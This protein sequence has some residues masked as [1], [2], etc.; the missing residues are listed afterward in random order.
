M[1][2]LRHHAFGPPAE[3]LRL[4]DVPMPEPGPGEVRVRLTHRGINLAD[5]LTIR[6]RYGRRPT[7]PAVGGNEGVGVV[8]AR[9]EGV[10]GLAVGQRVVPLGAGP[11]WQEYL[12]APPE[13]LLPV[14]A[15]VS[16]E[17]AAQLYVN[18]LTAWL[19]LERVADAAESLPRTRSGGDA[20]VLTAGASAVARCAI[21]LAA[22]RGLRPIAIVRRGEHADALRAL[23]AEVLVADANGEDARAQLRAL[24][25]PDGARAVFDAVA[26]EAGALALSALRHGGRHV[27]YGGLSGAPLAVDAGALIFRD[28]RVE[29]VWR[30]RWAAEAPAEAIRRAVGALADL[31]AEGALAL[32]VEATY[33]L[34]D[35]R[36]ALA[37]AAAPGRLGKVLLT[38]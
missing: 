29:G 32:P 33:D 11:T 20:L 4:D 1:R 22:R 28:V 10:E 24:V 23:G 19:L 37:H 36:E 27:V 38:G 2:A 12:L 30:T 25:G 3:V 5:L 7:L 21:Q 34:A 26:G 6:G 15:G 9:G 17:A 16:D 35:W 13:R 31:V 18:P 8:D 14:P